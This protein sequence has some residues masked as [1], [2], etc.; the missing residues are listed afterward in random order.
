MTARFSSIQARTGAVSD[1][2][3]F[4]ARRFL[5]IL[6][7]SSPR[8]NTSPSEWTSSSKERWMSLV[9]AFCLQLVRFCHVIALFAVPQECEEAVYLLTRHAGPLSA[10]SSLSRSSPIRSRPPAS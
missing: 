2:M 10:A 5:R 3:S 6:A 8:A 4:A 9:M 7:S 1:K